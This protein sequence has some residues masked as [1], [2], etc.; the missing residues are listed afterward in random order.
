MSFAVR[1]AEKKDCPAMLDIYSYYVQE[2][3]VSLEYTPPSLDGFESRFDAYSARYPWLVCE[4]DGAVAGYAYA[5]RFK[6][7]AAYD[8]S[9]ETTVYVQ[10]GMHRRGCGR[11]L[12]S[13]LLDILR[14]QGFLTA[15]SVICVPNEKSEAFHTAFGYTLRG[16]FPN[17][18]YKAGAWRSSGWYAL[19]L[20]DYSESPA[21]PLPIYELK[22][23]PAFSALLERYSKML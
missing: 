4:M 7:R 6:E 16:V 17:I 20:A 2:T 14:L 21:P 1:L 5:R 22:H 8:W 18:A 9:A 12:Y 13:C 10:H 11:A 15:V 23:L 3:V 19:T